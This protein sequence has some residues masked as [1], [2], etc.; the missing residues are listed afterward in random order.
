MRIKRSLMFALPR[1][2]ELSAGCLECRSP[3]DFADPLSLLEELLDAVGAESDVPLLAFRSLSPEAEDN[4]ALF[5]ALYCPSVQIPRQDSN[6]QPQPPQ[7]PTTCGNS[8]ATALQNS[9]QCP[10]KRS[11]RSWPLCRRQ[12]ANAC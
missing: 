8:P 12:N 5:A 7:P 4:A 10:P 3:E 6:P 2:A 1:F 9:V 11:W